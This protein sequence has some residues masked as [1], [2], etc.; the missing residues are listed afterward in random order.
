MSSTCRSLC[1]FSGSSHPCGDSDACIADQMSILHD[2]AGRFMDDAV[3]RELGIRLIAWDRPGYGQSDP[4]P[5]RSFQTFAGLLPVRDTTAASQ[6]CVS[7]HL[8]TGGSPLNAAPLL[9][10]RSTVVECAIRAVA[11][12]VL[13]SSWLNAESGMHLFTCVAL[14]KVIVDTSCRR[15]EAAGGSC[16]RTAVFRGR[17]VRRRTLHPGGGVAPGAPRAGGRG[18]LLGGLSRCAL[19]S[20]YQS[21]SSLNRA[22]VPCVGPCPV[23]CLQWKS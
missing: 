23:P 21:A 12:I 6:I 1:W 19:G 8:S 5:Q 2:S 20:L 3:F 16:G 4:Q 11:E 7:M 9:P 15:P 10:P 18:Q 13:G 14:F 17:H 22:F